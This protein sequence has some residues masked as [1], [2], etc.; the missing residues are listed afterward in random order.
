MS[1]YNHEENPR[2]DRHEGL[3][4]DNG[5]AG[6]DYGGMDSGFGESRRYD[7]FRPEPRRSGSNN[8]HFKNIAVTII[9]V[10]LVPLLL[11]VIDYKR[12]SNDEKRILNDYQLEMNRLINPA[13]RVRDSIREM[14]YKK[15]TEQALSNYVRIYREMYR[16]KDLIPTASHIT[17]WKIHNHGGILNTAEQQYITVLYTTDVDDEVPQ[18]DIKTDWQ[19]RELYTGYAWFAEQMKNEGFYKIGDITQETDFY[20][21]SAKSYSNFIGT[22]SIVGV[23][24]K[25][26]P[27]AM[28]FLTASFPYT[29]PV[30]KDEYLEVKLQNARGHLRTLINPASEVLDTREN[31][32]R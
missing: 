29:F 19:R 5:F 23:Y 4:M 6:G 10:A 9:S 16:L 17:V 31:A 21:G 15:E 2:Q 18:T 27:N 25:A 8:G 26:E 32:V 20:F 11:F 7:K 22:K 13:Q 30:S 12:T 1:D 14:Q 24:L 3:E 28:Y